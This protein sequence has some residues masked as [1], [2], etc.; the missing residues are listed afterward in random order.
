MFRDAGMAIDAGEFSQLES[1]TGVGQ[2]QC[3]QSKRDPGRIGQRGDTGI[4]KR[5]RLGVQ[6]E[7]FAIER[8]RRLQFVNGVDVVQDADGRDASV[9]SLSWNLREGDG[10]KRDEER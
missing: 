7:Y 1:E 4:G 8:E 3:S 9:R 2:A 6:A 10:G 5:A